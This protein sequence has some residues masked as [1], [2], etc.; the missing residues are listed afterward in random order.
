MREAEAEAAAAS[1][2]K[3]MECATLAAIELS[4]YQ[5]RRH[6]ASATIGRMRINQHQHDHSFGAASAAAKMQ[7]RPQGAP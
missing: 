6:R 5:C 4:N 3:V 1:V 2:K 7:G